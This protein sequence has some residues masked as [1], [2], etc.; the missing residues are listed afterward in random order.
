MKFV[1]SHNIISGFLRFQ[2]ENFILTVY[3]IET[4]G[5]KPNDGDRMI[6]FSAR[7]CF[8]SHD[9]LTEASS[10]NWYINPGRSIPED[11]VKLTGITD[12]FLADKP[13]EAEVIQEIADFIGTDPI[14]GYN[15]DHFDNIFLQLAYERAGLTFEPEDSVDIYRVIK[16]VIPAGETENL[17]LKTMIGYFGLSDCVQSSHNAMDDTAATLLIHNKLVALCRERFGEESSHLIQ[18][19]INSVNRYEKNTGRGMIRRLYINTDKGDFYFDISRRSWHVKDKRD[20]LN[21]YD[22]DDLIVKTYQFTG[23]STET[24]LCQYA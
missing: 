22:V 23:C 19:K 7:K 17:K 9:G 5:L 10:A 8:V 2:K 14:C 15:N 20:R 21:R 3:D 13:R 16:E 18:C 1:D 24:E 12:E 11:I 6:Q 4:T